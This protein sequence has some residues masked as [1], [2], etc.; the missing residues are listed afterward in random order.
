MGSTRSVQSPVHIRRNLDTFADPYLSDRTETE[1]S[2]CGACGAV[3]RN[4]RWY[5]EMKLTEVQKAEV[6]KVVC[7]ACKKIADGLPGGVVTL[8]GTFL[9]K[10][11]EEILHLI[12]NEEKKARTFNPLERIMQIHDDRNGSLEITTTTE[13]LAQRIART[14]HK[15]CAGEVEYKWSEDVKLIRAYWRRDL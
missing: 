6:N 1:I 2:L 4:K 5:R 12:Y 11:K 14:V 15:A 7:P 9:R 8:E 3:Y 13:K 10:H